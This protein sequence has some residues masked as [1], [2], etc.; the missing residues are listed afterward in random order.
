M[1]LNL[2]INTP[3]QAYFESI[4]NVVTEDIVVN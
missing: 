1:T 3:H 4:P 2:I